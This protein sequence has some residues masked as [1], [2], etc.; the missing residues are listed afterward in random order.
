MLFRFA[1]C[2]TT[3]SAILVGVLAKAMADPRRTRG[4]TRAIATFMITLA[5]RFYGACQHVTDGGRL[6]AFV[7]HLS[8]PGQMRPSGPFSGHPG[9]KVAIRLPAPPASEGH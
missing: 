2:G 3:I 4:R 5:Y 9:A 6:G 8:P 1:R 7:L